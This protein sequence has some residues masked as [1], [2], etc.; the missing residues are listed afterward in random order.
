MA[1]NKK[2]WQSV[3]ELKEGSVVETLRNNEFVE[4][5]PTD[6]FLGDKETLETSSTSRRDFLKYVGFSTAAASLA[7]CEGPVRKSIP[8]VV[9]P[10]N[11][12]VGVADWYATTIADGFDFANVLVKTREG[13]PIQIM[14]NKEIGGVTN[15]RT[16][17]SV[18]SLYDSNLRLKEPRKGT[19]QISWADADKEII[20]ELERLN[21][22]NE[23]VVLLTGSLA[24]PST[25]KVIADFIA[26]YP[27]VK[28][29]V[30]DAV[31]ESGTADAFEAMY[32]TRALPNYDFSK[33]EVI[34]SIGAD[35]L[36]DWQGGYE[37]SY[38]EGR[39]PELGK[40]S[41][42]VQIESNMSLAGA[43]ADKRI[44]A[45]PSDQVYALI[46][47]YNT[48]T[49]ANM[50]SKATAHDAEIKKLATSLQKAGNKGV[51]VTGLNDKNAQLIA[52]AIN[53]A[54]NS[55]VIDVVNVNNTRQGNDTEVAQLL[56]DL[57]SGK[58]KGLVTYNVNPNYS[59]TGFA[60][61]AKK[62][63]LSVAISTQ[64]DA[65]ATAMQYAL[66]AP[67]NLESWGDVSASANTYG[68]M[69]PTISPIFNTRQIQDVLLKWS[70]SS[71]NYYDILKEF[72]STNV[73]NG[74]SWNQALHDGFFK[75]ELESVVTVNDIDI[76]TAAATL[77]KNTT[78]SQY[79]LNLYTSTA[80]GDGKQANNPWLQELPDPI[81]R[82]S[83]DNYLTVSMADAKELGFD[84]PVKDNGAIDGNYANVTVNGVTINNIPVMVQPGQAKGSFGLA[85]GYGRTQG[86]KEEMQVGVNAYPFYANGNSIQYNVSIEKASGWHKFACTQ[87]QKTIAG[88]NDILKEAT[89]KEV[90]NKKLDPKHTWNKP[91]MVSYDHQEVEAKTIDLWDEH[92]REIGHHFNLS[93]DLTSCTGCGAC[94]VACHAENNVP[95]V[96][97]HEVR[98]GRDMH[99]LRIDRYYSSEVN[100]KQ[101]EASMTI[102]EFKAQNPNIANQE[103]ERKYAEKILELGGGDLFA[104]LETSAENPQ[105]AFQ[106]MMCQHCNHAPCETVCPVAATSHGR[107]GQN[108]MAYNRCVGTR[109]CANNCPYRVRRFNWFNYSDNSEFDFNM[110]ND[111][112]KMVLNPDVVVRSR[113]VMEKC[114]MC[115]QM[116][117]ATI[118]KA[119][120]EGRA[121]KKDEFK[122][123]CSEAC[124][125]GAMVFGDVNN[126][127]DKV[128]QLKEDNR[129]YHVLDYIGTKPNVVYQVKVRNTNEA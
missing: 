88:R 14:P 33:A 34:A 67:H 66:P 29:V 103:V 55:E 117:Q 93:I 111:Y 113:G 91:A 5:I 39:K 48:V 17:A 27:N 12:V 74:A 31:S 10:D 108:Q 13:R 87:V 125:T 35:I 41:Y 36:G 101:V 77:V 90:L 21:A 102:E 23:S 70:G 53:K 99:W 97:K 40:M 18:L 38:A 124:S 83:W 118:L 65:T 58:V 46:N 3:E 123:A 42:H 28:H 59:L 73:L 25:D 44:V 122:T 19:T 20:A 8:Y 85:L 116:T 2:Y 105:V 51:V 1:S 109:Y 9:Q 129:A 24:S 45:K 98:V 79:E 7:A 71:V 32:G 50:P 68:L 64:D 57:S 95:V 15:A 119:K 115:I 63:S 114:S 60:D 61:A 78:P 62:A 107:Q 96:G 92:N 106:P 22:A 82:A 110:N 69:Q 6:E 76:N 56:K 112:G 16:Q 47:L 121:V 43:N 104:A 37:K 26:K 30:Y 128:T 126:T 72:W 89:L 120:K 52:L 49:G 75:K 54:L 127:E 81:T 84:N 11:I 4:E 80:L 100:E 86:L 94:V